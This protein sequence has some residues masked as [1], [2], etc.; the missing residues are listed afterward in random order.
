MIHNK[1]QTNLTFGGLLIEYTIVLSDLIKVSSLYCKECISPLGEPLEFAYPGSLKYGFAFKISPCIETKT[2][3]MVDTPGIHFS[4]CPPDQVLRRLKHTFPQLYRFGLIRS[5]PEWQYTC[6]QKQFLRLSSVYNVKKYGLPGNW[7][8]YKKG[9]L[10][11]ALHFICKL[12]FPQFSL[13]LDF[14]RST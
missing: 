10:D 4:F 7:T 8:E 6:W 12:D 14:A 11:F 2:C 3:S 5:P 9:F 13:L 1:G